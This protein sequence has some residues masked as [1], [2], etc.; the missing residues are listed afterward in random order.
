MT[1]KELALEI[2]YKY[3]DAEQCVIL[4]VSGDIDNDL[5]RLEAEID[6]YT[7]MIDERS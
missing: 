4:E 3:A 6:R 1:L 5:S 2:L 7:Q